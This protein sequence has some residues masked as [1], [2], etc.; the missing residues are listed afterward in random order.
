[1]KLPIYQVDAFSSNLFD[2]NPAAVCSLEHWLDDKLM[3]LYLQGEINLSS[4][5]KG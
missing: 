3:Q 5:F 2:G 1:M 4:V